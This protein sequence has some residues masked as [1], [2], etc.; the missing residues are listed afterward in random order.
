MALI[1]R[2]NV[3]DLFTFTFEHISVPKP[4]L[5]LLLAI[6]WPIWKNQLIKHVQK[7]PISFKNSLL[8]VH[9]EF[10]PRISFFS[11]NLYVG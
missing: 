2:Q 10:W 11:V 5:N 6:K 8:T 9:F 1:A 3:F 7:L 4:N